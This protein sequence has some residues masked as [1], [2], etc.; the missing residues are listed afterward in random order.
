VVVVIVVVGNVIVVT[1]PNGPFAA[2]TAA[3]NK[4]AKRQ[5]SAAAPI[6]TPRLIAPQCRENPC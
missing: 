4:P 1:A 2:R 3:L 5:A 6:R